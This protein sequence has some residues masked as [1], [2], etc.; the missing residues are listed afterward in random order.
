MNFFACSIN[1]SP[2]KFAV[3]TNKSNLSGCVSI[4]SK[5][6]VPIDPVDP[7]IAIPLFVDM[8]TK[9]KDIVLKKSVSGLFIEVVLHENAVG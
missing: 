1:K 7:K 4:T 3:R 5:A 2:L 8:V 9:V 6:C